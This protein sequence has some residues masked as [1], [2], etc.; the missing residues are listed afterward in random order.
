[1]TL[2][3]KCPWCGAERFVGTAETSLRYACGSDAFSWDASELRQSERCK[4]NVA[5]RERDASRDVADVATQ[6]VIELL[7]DVGRLTAERD[8][9]DRAA[10]WLYLEV[11][12][13]LSLQIAKREWPWLEQSNG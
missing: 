10:R 8:E 3:E 12:N 7:D 11:E 6:R 1:M 2:P 9:R 5:E 4:L 13:K